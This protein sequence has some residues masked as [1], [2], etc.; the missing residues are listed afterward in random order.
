VFDPA[1]EFDR[2]VAA[3]HELGYPAVAGLTDDAFA[4]LVGPLREA[5]VAQ[6]PMT[7]PTP[8]RLPFVLVLTQEHAPAERTMPLTTLAGKKTPG[9]VDRNNL[10]PGEIAT[11][12]PI[13]GLGINGASVYLVLDVDRGDEFLN[14]TPNEAALIIAERGRTP[15]TVEEGIAVITQFPEALEKNKCFMLAGSRCGDQRVPAL[16]IS[17]RAP[18]LGWCWAGNRHTWLGIASCG[19]RAGTGL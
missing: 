14:V 16:W 4:D 13:E 11:F 5:V 17:E 9:F 18:K 12:T 1:A 3:L 7:P 15:L 10:K 19:G 6:G 2:Q 8:A